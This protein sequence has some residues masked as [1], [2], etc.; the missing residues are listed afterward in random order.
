MSW[1]WQVFC[2]DTLDQTT[3]AGCFGKG[4]DITYLDWLLSAWGWTVSVSLLSL[5]LVLV[6]LIPVILLSRT[7]RPGTRR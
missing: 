7:L 5:A 6:G 2:T 3:V 4:G 1:D